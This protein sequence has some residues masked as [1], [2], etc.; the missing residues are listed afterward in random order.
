MAKLCALAHIELVQE[1]GGG[2]GSSSSES[3]DVLDVAAVQ[4]DVGAM[5]RCMQTMRRERVGERGS[6][7]GGH[8]TGENRRREGKE[9]EGG[10]DGPWGGAV[11]WAA[12]MQEVGSQSRVVC[13]S[14]DGRTLKFDWLCALLWGSHATRMLI[15]MVSPD[16]PSYC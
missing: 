7:G 9:G 16:K 2:S 14:A 11:P 13:S 15:L 3:S 6:G 12:P 10:E 8:S 4:R 1:G 5:L